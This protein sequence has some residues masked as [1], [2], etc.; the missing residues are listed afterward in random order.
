MKQQKKYIY[1]LGVAILLACLIAYFVTP[2]KRSVSNP[3]SRQWTQITVDGGPMNGLWEVRIKDYG[4]GLKLDKWN[5]TG[6]PDWLDG[7]RAANGMSGL[8]YRDFKKNVSSKLLT[9]MGLENESEFNKMRSPLGGLA[10]D[11]LV[12]KVFYLRRQSL[13]YAFV[14]NWDNRRGSREDAAKRMEADGKTRFLGSW[15]PLQKQES[16]FILIGLDELAENGVKFFPYQ[17][18]DAMDKVLVTKR[19]VWNEVSQNYLAP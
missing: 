8:E 12:Y 2:H 1:G 14:L 13:E 4:E 18:A 19:L 11:S 17:Y 6:K 10:P 7:F 15:L 3:V 16:R 9:D 5:V